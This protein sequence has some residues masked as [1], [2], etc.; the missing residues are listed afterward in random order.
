MTAI[1]RSTRPKRVD[2]VTV[3]F[4]GYLLTW[5]CEGALRKWVAPGLQQ[6]LYFSRVPF[7][8]IAIIL[9]LR[10]LRPRLPFGAVAGLLTVTSVIAFG[11]LH[12]ILGDQS[13]VSAVLGSRLMLEAILTPLAFSVLLGPHHAIL[14]CR[15][16]GTTR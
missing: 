7:V 2:A 15:T 12:V 5:L 4:V 8:I 3:I 11:C 9:A 6:P 16:A 14:G 1:G 10:R 13:F